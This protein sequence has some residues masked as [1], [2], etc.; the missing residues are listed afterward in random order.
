MK[1]KN[2]ALIIKNK[3]DGVKSILDIPKD[4]IDEL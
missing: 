3:K 4:K 2:I 1:I